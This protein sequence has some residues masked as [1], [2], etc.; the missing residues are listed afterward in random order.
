MP[1]PYNWPILT[2]K[3]ITI[4]RK[5]YL[6]IGSAMISQ[7]NG[8]FNELIRDNREKARDNREKSW[9]TMIRTADPLITNQ[10]LYQLSYTSTKIEQNIQHQGILCNPNKKSITNRHKIAKQ[11]QA[12]N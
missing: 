7:L 8:K 9:K 10:L 3:A 6:S 12:L 4:Q 5:G 2:A 1:H 11:P